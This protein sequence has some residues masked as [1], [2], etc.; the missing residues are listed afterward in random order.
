MSLLSFDGR[1][2]RSQYWL[3]NFVVPFAGYLVIGFLNA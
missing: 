2:R 3:T 1:I